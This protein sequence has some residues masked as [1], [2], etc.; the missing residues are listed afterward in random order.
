MPAH[1][2]GSPPSVMAK[3]NTRAHLVASCVALA[4]MIN[5][6]QTAEATASLDKLVGCVW[7]TILGETWRCLFVCREV[8][9]GFLSLF[10]GQPGEKCQGS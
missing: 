5:A 1:A 6:V 3:T 9:A 2:S 7:H 10:L 4:V 8:P